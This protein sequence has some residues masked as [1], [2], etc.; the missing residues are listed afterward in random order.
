MKQKKDDPQQ[1]HEIPGIK[2]N[3]KKRKLTKRK[4][5]AKEF[6]DVIKNNKIDE[7]FNKDKPKNQINDIVICL[8][9]LS[10]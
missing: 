8:L 2:D 9:I 6:R 4:K 1:L 3:G 7:W 5:E 10:K